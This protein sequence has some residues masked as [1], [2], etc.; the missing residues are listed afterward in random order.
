MIYYVAIALVGATLLLAFF[1]FPETSY[2][3]AVELDAEG[4][5]VHYSEKLEPS[6]SQVE[7][8]APVIPKKKTYIQRLKIFS[9]TYTEESFWR[10]FI[11]PF[12]L[13]CVPISLTHKHKLTRTVSSPPSFGCHSSNP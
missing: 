4:L 2:I 11:R 9:G 12:A 5:P 13:M 1:T 10:L 8:E 7:T 3:R 6:T